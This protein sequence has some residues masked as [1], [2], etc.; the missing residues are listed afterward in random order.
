M[1]TVDVITT[2]LAAGAGAG[3][4]DTASAA[5][6]DA[7]TGLKDLL[8]RRLGGDRAVLQALEA[9]QE[10]AEPGVW[11][12]QIGDALTAIGADRDEHIIAAAY[13]L[14]ELSDLARSSAVSYHVDVREA[15]PSPP[16]SFETPR[17]SGVLA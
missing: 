14:L 5:V 11:L 6:K 17:V 7:Y 4:T 15:K 2:A 16:R 13:R 12:T 10:G 3:M 9:D 8:K 1:S